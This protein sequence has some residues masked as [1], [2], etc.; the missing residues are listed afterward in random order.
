MVTTVGTED[1]LDELLNDLIQL[2][3][4]AA[5]AYQAAIDRLDNPAFK[6]AMVEFKEDHLRHTRELGGCL[7]QL[8]REPPHEGDVK[9]IVTKGKVVIAGL[10]G[11]KAILQAMLTNENDTVTAYERAARFQDARADVRQVIQ[12]A[13]DDEVRHRAWIDSAIKT[14]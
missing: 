4:D 10:M 11:D 8:G 13:C 6:A 5:Q 7:S 9:E 2:D 3:Y 12:R 1:K 14:A